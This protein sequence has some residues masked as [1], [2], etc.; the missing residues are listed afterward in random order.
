MHCNIEEGHG[1]GTLEETRECLREGASNKKQKL[2]QQ[3]NETRNL[4][5]AYEYLMEI[6]QNEQDADLHGFIEESMLRESNKIVLDGIEHPKDSTKPGVYSNRRRITMFRGELYEYQLPLDM[7]VAVNNLLDKFNSLYRDSQ[8]ESDEEKKVYKLFKTCSWFVFEMLDLHPFGDGNGRLCRLLFSYVLSTCTPF[9]TPIYNV[10]SPSC[11]GDFKN[12]LIAARE[13]ADRHPCSL[14]TMIIECN[15]YAWKHFMA[16][17]KQGKQN[18]QDADLH[19]DIKE[20]ML[21]DA[22]KKIIDGIATQKIPQ[23]QVFAATD[24][25]LPSLMEMLLNIKTH[26]ICSF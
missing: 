15:L 1:C 21:R 9:A 7:E 6:K 14:T 4:E 23:K 10:W 26:Q 5:R 19:G 17:V 25:V 8:N 20:S 3:E 22:N 2:S 12:A 16:E 18:E 11:K 24:H 13:S